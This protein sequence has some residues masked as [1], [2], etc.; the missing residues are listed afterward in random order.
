MTY[1]KRRLNM[2]IYKREIKEAVIERGEFD[3][4]LK[5][6][7]DQNKKLILMILYLTGARPSEIILI[8]KKDITWDDQMASFMIQTK[9]GGY[10]RTLHMN[11]KICYINDIISILEKMPNGRINHINT[12]MGIEKMVNRATLNKYS[13]YSFRHSR[14]FKI[15]RSGATIFELMAFKGSKDSKSVM[16]YV[17]KAGI[18]NSRIM[19]S[20]D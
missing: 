1:L 11:R 8:E 17:V 4:Y 6:V 16:P 18:M 5:N 14:L 10:L 20:I 9:K 15:A 7:H 2:P 3:G 12:P 13:P 19:D